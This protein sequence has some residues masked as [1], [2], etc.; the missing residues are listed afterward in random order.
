M[1]CVVV[2]GRPCRR[3][4]IH[5]VER[6]EHGGVDEIELSPGYGNDGIQAGEQQHSDVDAGRRGKP[7][8]ILAEAGPRDEYQRGPSQAEQEPI[9]ARH[10]GHCIRGLRGVGC[11]LPREGRVDRILG[12]DRDQGEDGDREGLRKVDLGGLDRPAEQECGAKDGCTRE[13]GH[14]RCCGFEAHQPTTRP[15]EAREDRQQ[16]LD[17][18]SRDCERIGLGVEIHGL[19]A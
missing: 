7:D 9:A 18:V 15:G 4:H 12:Q 2:A 5:S 10:V 17:P 14:H 19:G 11:S 13:Q 3:D 16:E 8:A 6:D 1:S